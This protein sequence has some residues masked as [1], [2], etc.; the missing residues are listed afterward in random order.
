M[1]AVT[2]GNDFG[3]QEEL[4]ALTSIL[5]EKDSGVGQHLISLFNLMETGLFSNFEGEMS[6]RVWNIGLKITTSH[7]LRQRGGEDLAIFTT[8]SIKENTWSP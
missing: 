3:A 7:W 2:I 1:V 6:R 5:G 8:M 4:A